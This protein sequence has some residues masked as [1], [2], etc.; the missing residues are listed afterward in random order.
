MPIVMFPKVPFRTFVFFATF[1]MSTDPHS[2]PSLWRE[3]WKSWPGNENTRRNSHSFC[4]V[5]FI[6]I[7]PL[8]L[9]YIR[10]QSN[11]KGNPDLLCGTKWVQYRKSITRKVCMRVSHWNRQLSLAARFESSGSA[12]SLCSLSAGRRRPAATATCL[13]RRSPSERD[14]LVALLLQ[15]DRIVTSY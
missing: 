9:R 1:R 3:T 4:P 13:H 10:S 11:Q 8:L 14:P 7:G 12:A 5:W 6:D 15:M 2:W